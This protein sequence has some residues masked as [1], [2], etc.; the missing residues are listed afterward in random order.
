[1][2]IRGYPWASS[3]G[4]LLWLQSCYIPVGIRGYLARGYF[5]PPWI[6]FPWASVGIRGYSVGIFTFPWVSVGTPWAFRGYLPWASMGILWV[7]FPCISGRPC[8][9]FVD[10]SNGFETQSTG[11]LEVSLKT[12]SNVAS[13][14]PV[15]YLHIYIH[16]CIYIYT[17]MC[18]HNTHVH[19]YIYVFIH[20][21]I[22]ILSHRQG[23]E[24]LSDHTLLTCLYKCIAYKCTYVHLFTDACM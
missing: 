12:A 2:G 16:I 20:M 22:H 19:I 13:S 24:G 6:S 21:Y 17:C 18:T 11:C 15:V 8:V 9:F 7:L 3:V 10:I 4:I 14:R 5:S 1:M 23:T